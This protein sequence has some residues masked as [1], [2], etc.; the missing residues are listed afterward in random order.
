MRNISEL[1]A[2]SKKCRKNLKTGEEL[3][4]YHIAMYKI[5]NM[6][7]SWLDAISLSFTVSVTP[8][9]TECVDLCI[10][11]D[12]ESVLSLCLQSTSNE[13]YFDVEKNVYFKSAFF[14]NSDDDDDADYFEFNSSNPDWDNIIIDVTNG[15]AI[16]IMDYLRSNHSYNDSDLGYAEDL[17]LRFYDGTFDEYIDRLERQSECDSM[18]GGAEGMLHDPEAYI[19][20]DNKYSEF[21]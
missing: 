8:Y 4:E 17:L 16:M 12:K 11:H 3:P 15:A 14:D 5:S 18:M 13:L 7:Y 1:N 20:L 9:S 2:I 19:E 6:L 10:K 21:E